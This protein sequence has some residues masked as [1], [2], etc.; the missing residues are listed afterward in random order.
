MTTPSPPSP[1]ASDSTDGEQ[2]NSKQAARPA[3]SFQTSYISS[4]HC[5]QKPHAYYPALEQRLVVETRSSEELLELET[6]K[7]QL[8]N[9]KV[10]EWFI[11]VDFS[12]EVRSDCLGQDDQE[13]INNRLKEKKLYLAI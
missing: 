8:T 10:D 11:I 6:R 12:V 7:L 13:K 4:E 2:L 5:Y 9:A 3:C 1:H